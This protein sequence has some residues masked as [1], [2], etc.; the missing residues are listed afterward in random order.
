[1]V[2]IRF[3]NGKLEALDG[4]KDVVNYND[5]IEKVIMPR[6]KA[7]NA[8][9][10][11]AYLTKADVALAPLT[12]KIH[13]RNLSV[14]PRTQKTG[15]SLNGFFKKIDLYTPLPNDDD[16]VIQVLIRAD[17]KATEIQ[18]YYFPPVVRYHTSAKKTEDYTPPSFHDSQAIFPGMPAYAALEV[19]RAPDSLLL[20][21]AFTEGQNP[22]GFAIENPNKTWKGYDCNPFLAKSSGR[23]QRKQR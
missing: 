7:L 8:D 18:P 10:F 19:V 16:L 23:G 1:M 22:I 9:Q 12:H 15:V 17:V 5:V 6:L 21:Y 2:K 4:I 20:P 13:D 14:D 3:R 11:Y